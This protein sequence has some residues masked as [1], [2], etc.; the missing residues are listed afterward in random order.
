[1]EKKCPYCNA[2][3]NESDNICTVCNK[4]LNI[5]CPYCRQTIKVYDEICPQC[6][7]ILHE[8][9][10]PKALIIA[11]FLIN[12]LWILGNILGLYFLAKF[13]QLFTIDKSVDLLV[14]LGE[15][16]TGSLIFVVIPYIIAIIRK[17]KVKFAIAGLITNFLLAI[18]FILCLAILY[19]THA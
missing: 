13:P 16:T 18:I 12:L 11:G 8:K 15:I 5:Q 19:V 4:D 7:S 14:N 1:M 9:E 3:I 6:S 10:Y 17:Y 2:I